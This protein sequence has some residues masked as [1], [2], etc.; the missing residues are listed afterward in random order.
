MISPNQ[1]SSLLTNLSKLCYLV[2]YQ[3]VKPPNAALSETIS[4]VDRYINEQFEVSQLEAQFRAA[5]DDDT[6][7]VRSQM[8]R[9]KNEFSSNP[10]LTTQSDSNIKKLEHLNHAKNHLQV[11]VL[12]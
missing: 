6:T 12:S 3:P 4:H 1:V 8:N 5:E 9:K 10:I 2:S 7:P 11:F